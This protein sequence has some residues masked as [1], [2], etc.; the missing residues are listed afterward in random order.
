[1][2]LIEACHRVIPQ[3]DRMHVGRDNPFAERIRETC[4]DA[5]ARFARLRGQTSE[6]RSRQL[7]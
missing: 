2:A 7:T 5:V 1:L 4:R 6:S 3:L